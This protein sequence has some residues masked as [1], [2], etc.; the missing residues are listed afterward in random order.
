MTATVFCHQPHDFDSNGY[1]ACIAID[2][3]SMVENQSVK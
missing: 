2:F 3:F 1:G